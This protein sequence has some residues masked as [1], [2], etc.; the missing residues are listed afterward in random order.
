M[1]KFLFILT[2]TLVTS[3]TH[4]QSYIYDV[5]RDGVVDITDVTCLV[6]N[7]LGEANPGE[8]QGY[9]ELCF[10]TKVFI[11]G[12]GDSKVLEI[13]SGTGHYAAYSNNEA[14]VA[15]SVAGS[16]VTVTANGMGSAVLTVTDTESLQSAA[17]PVTVVAGLALSTDALRLVPG[18]IET[19]DISS[20]NGN[21]SVES[22]NEDVATVELDGTSSFTVTAIGEG[23][24]TITLTDMR[25]GQVKVIAVTVAYPDLVLPSTDTILLG[26]TTSSTTVDIISGS[27]SYDVTSSAPAVAT[28]EMD[29][30]T[31]IVTAM[32]RGEVIITVTD[33][34]SGQ[35]ATFQVEV[36]L[37]LCPDAN[38]PHLIDLGLPSGKRWSCCNVDGTHPENQTPIN[39]GGYYSWGEKQ[40]KTIYT[41]TN[42][43]YYNFFTQEFT[44]IGADIAGTDKDVAH[45]MWGKRWQMPS[46]DDMKEMFQNCTK[47]YFTL[48]NVNGVLF[49]GSNGKSIFLPAA[50]YKISEST[51]GGIR[52]G[53]GVTGVHY[54]AGEY[55]FY[56]SSTFDVANS[57]K[58]N[59]YEFI[60]TPTPTF[61][62]SSTG[63]YLGLTVRPIYDFI[64]F[65]LSKANVEMGYDEMETVSITSGNGSYTVVSS[66]PGVA[67]ASLS[68]TNITI[69]AVSAGTAVL[70]VTDNVG[71]EEAIIQ[72][73]VSRDIFGCPDAHHPHMIDLGLPSGTKWAC[74]NVDASHPESQAPAHLG[75]YYAWGETEV[76]DSYGSDTYL[77]YNNDNYVSIGSDIAGTQYDVAFVKWGDVWQM[78]GKDQVQELVSKCSY[79]WTE[80]NGV[81][82]ALFTGP[83]GTTIF[84]PATGYRLGDILN[85]GDYGYYWSSTQDPSSLSYAYSLVFYSGNKLWDNSYFRSFGQNVRPV[86]K[87]ILE[88]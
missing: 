1:K 38:H 27:G 87:Y 6:N 50:G 71:G 30:S 40:E 79:R 72:V 3:T 53:G 18:G 14:V 56:W 46:L 59:A 48:N 35:T 84:L 47:K 73:T 44:G 70:T 61:E 49:I 10:S 82:G 26:L 63:R 78:P 77:Y 68:G 15:V 7:I 25:T 32:G 54:G 55:G 43:S 45:E 66:N 9:P 20:G 67:T 57:N 5:N 13:S 74:C 41:L 21:Y 22:A 88:R 60:F 62:W 52:P 29:G 23:E 31:I 69:S 19:V 75:D 76:K 11:V 65:V 36:V 86:C 80:K 85:G 16:A 4:A 42:Y 2:L 39:Y 58:S 81:Y 12:E 83:A 51:S 37:P 17:V 64:P 33:M 34:K 24:T 28:V 8:E